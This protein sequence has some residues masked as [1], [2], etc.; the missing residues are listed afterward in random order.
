MTT[1][2]ITT[3]TEEEEDTILTETRDRVMVGTEKEIIIIIIQN[4]I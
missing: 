1:V 3:T 2:I 4:K